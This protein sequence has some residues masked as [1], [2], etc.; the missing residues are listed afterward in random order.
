MHSNATIPSGAVTAHCLR[1]KPGDELMSSLKRAASTILGGSATE[2][3]GSAF[4]I[5]A[6]G[7]LQDVALR[8]ANASR[9]DGDRNNDGNDIRRYRN[10]RF[11]IVSLT[12][13]F[14]RYNGCHVHISLADAEGKTLGG[15]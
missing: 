1:L 11:E 3:C 7:S 15:I 10:R 12:G 8:L 4:V 13:T 9:M 14:G 5:T 2:P 6:V